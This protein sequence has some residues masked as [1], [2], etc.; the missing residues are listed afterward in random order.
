METTCTAGAAGATENLTP[1]SESPSAIFVG[2]RP[3]ETGEKL[4]GRDHEVAEL[5]GLM[6]CE[7]VVLLHAPSG[8][9][10]TSL[11]QAGLIPVMEEEGFHVPRASADEESVS[12]APALPVGRSLSLPAKPIVLRV[13]RPPRVDDPAKSNRYLLSVM[14]NLEAMREKSA[15]RSLTDLATISFATYIAELIPKPSLL[16]FDQFEEI[17]TQDPTDDAVKREFFHQ[18]GIALQN[19][20][21]WALFT[22]RE[23]FLP[24]LRP[25]FNPLPKRLA[26]SF[27][28]DFLR[29]DQALAAMV[30]PTTEA[31]IEFKV[32]DALVRNLLLVNVQLPDG[33]FQKKEG[34]YV[35]PVLLQVVCLRLLEKNAG[36]KSIEEGDVG[37]DLSQGVSKVLEDYYTDIVLKACKKAGVKERDV[38]NW[39]GRQL[40]HD[41]VRHPVRMGE[42]VAQGINQGCLDVLDKAF[43]VRKELRGGVFWYELAHDRLIDPVIAGNLS[44]QAKLSTFQKQAELWDKQ[45]RPTDLLVRDNVLREGERLAAEKAADMTDAER[46]YLKASQGHLKAE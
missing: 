8:A 24:A 2:P 34:V 45:G 27:R 20:V 6:I 29:R 35:E 14:L 43:L 19:P 13:N 37:C 36:K 15:R 11:I 10:K 40:I 38:R 46:A 39:V 3:L 9:G 16:I 33:T 5:S 28:L 1:P 44:F 25:Y 18:V 7:R 30:K 17:M 41:R 21:V 31:K 23:D 26:A 42:E 12:L 22:M 32:A 4:Y